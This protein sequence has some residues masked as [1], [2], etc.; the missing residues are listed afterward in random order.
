MRSC[1]PFCVACLLTSLAPM[2]SRVNAQPRG[3]A[4]DPF[5][6]GEARSAEPR[7]PGTPARH[8][9]AGTSLKTRPTPTARQRIEWE[10]EHTTELD[11]VEM[12]L[13]DVL[14]YLADRHQIP[15]FL[16][17]KKLE[18]AS[19]APDTPVTQTLRNV[20]L[21]A[22]LELALKEHGLDYYPDEVLVITTEQDAASRAELRVYD[23]R[24]L[25]SQ[26]GANGT[27]P[28]RVAR[29]LEM[30]QTSIEP[31][32]WRDSSDPFGANTRSA[33]DATRRPQV[34][35]ISEFDG[36]LVI[37]HTAKTHGKIAQLVNLLREAAGQQPKS[38]KAV[39]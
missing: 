10:L 5:G 7:Q 14:T 16:N 39:R 28:A 11:V 9:A 21:A 19:I 36:Q 22:A 23:C 2:A 37:A 18:G 13:R 6:S 34:G 27:D 30:I 12:P 25:L 8:R 26:A 20:R 15:I 17:V 32:T 31:D 29:L 24:D 3:D 33:S 35:S 4:A 1:L 38:A